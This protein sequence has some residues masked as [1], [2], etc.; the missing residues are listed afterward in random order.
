LEFDSITFFEEEINNCEI[1]KIIEQ[2]SDKSLSEKIFILTHIIF[3]KLSDENVFNDSTQK[4]FDQSLF[5]SLIDVKLYDENKNIFSNNGFNQI[6]MVNFYIY[7]DIQY[8]FY[9]YPVL[10]NIKQDEFFLPEFFRTLVEENFFVPKG[11]EYFFEKGLYYYFTGNKIEALHLIVPQ[12]ENSLR[13]ILRKK[14][15]TTI[16]YS[17][18]LEC[19]KIDIPELINMCA[20]SNLLNKKLCFYLHLLFDGDLCNVRNDLSH[21]FNKEDTFNSSKYDIL[22][23][24]VLYILISEDQEKIET[25]D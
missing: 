2:F 3:N 16:Q 5:L 21:G 7:S 23:F 25:T 8:L 18:G 22:I 15:P 10:E 6:K 24:L 14:E 19:E 20:N 4:Y 1:L 13:Y 11:H 9:I 17:K 12:I